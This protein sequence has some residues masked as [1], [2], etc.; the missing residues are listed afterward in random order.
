MNWLRFFKSL[1]ALAALAQVLYAQPAVRTFDDPRLQRWSKQLLDGQR[2]ATLKAVED[3]LVSGNPHPY[4]AEAWVKI[5]MS[6]DRLEPA[7]QSASPA[8]RAA[9]GSRPEIA[10]L[11]KKGHAKELLAK[12]PPSAAS[13]ITDVYS[14]EDLGWSAVNLRRY[15]DAAAYGLR[16]ME[17][18][19]SGFA[20]VWLLSTVVTWDLSLRAQLAEKF[21]PGTA[22]GDTPK[23]RFLSYEF[24]L[25]SL[26]ALDHL[27]EAKKLDSILPFDSE[28]RW[29]EANQL[30]TLER[31]DEAAQAYES[32]TQLFAFESLLPREARCLAALGRWADARKVAA[33]AAALGYPAANAAR[34]TEYTLA[35]AALDAGEKGEARRLLEAAA[36][37]WPDAPNIQ[38]KLARLEI[39]SKRGAQSLPHAR[40]AAA[41]SPDNLERQ[42]LLIEALREAKRVPESWAQFEKTDAAFTEKSDEMF[43]QGGETLHT[44]ERQED[45][46]ALYRRAVQEFPTSTY[47]MNELADALAMAGHKK[48]ALDELRISLSHGPSTWELGKLRT[49]LKEANP[50]S[51]PAQADTEIK[52][53]LD[54]RPWSNTLWEDLADHIEGAD[55]AARKLALFRDAAAKNPGRNWPWNQAMWVLLNDERWADAETLANQALDAT[56]TG[57]AADRASAVWDWSRMVVAHLEKER[58][59][60]AVLEKALANLDAY[61]AM[62]SYVGGY[63]PNRAKLLKALGRK[64]EAA[65]ASEKAMLYRP[66]DEDGAWQLA[67]EY[68]TELGTGKAMRDFE[69]YVD[70]DPYNSTRVKQLVQLN[71]MWTSNPARTL[72]LLADAKD[73]VPEAYDAGYE[74][75][76]RSNLGDYG[77]RYRVDYEHSTSISPSD[78]YVQWYQNTRLHAQEEKL[79]VRFDPNDALIY[80]V[81]HADGRVVRRKK[82][83]L[84]GKLML[85]QVDASKLEVEHDENGDDMKKI[86]D[87]AGNWIRLEYD[88]SHSIS[89]MTGNDGTELTFEYNRMKKPIRIAYKGLGEITVTY[90][91]AG[92]I[93]QVDSTAGRDIALKV[94]GAFQK[95]LDMIRPFESE[96]SREIPELPFK[97]ARADALRA[98]VEVATTPAATRRADLALARYLLDHIADRRAYGDEIQRTLASLIVAGREPGATAAVKVDA[99]AAADLW[100]QTARVLTPHGLPADEWTNW[101]QVRT[102]LE[103][104]PA[105]APSVANAAHTLLAKLEKAP[106]TLLPSAK[107]LP[108]SYIDSPGFWRRYPWSELLPQAVRTAL[109]QCLLVRANHDVVVGTDHGLAILSRGFWKWYGFDDVRAKFSPNV[110]PVGVGPTSNIL[111][112]AEAE[113]KLYVGSAKGL[114]RIAGAY[115]STVTRW[116]G[117]EDGLPSA[118]I[119]ALQTD[120]DRVF[121]GT[122]KG[123]RVLSKDNIAKDNTGSAGALDNE[124]IVLLRRLVN[125]PDDPAQ[126]VVATAS[127]VQALSGKSATTLLSKPVIDLAWADESSRLLALADL[128][129]GLHVYALP[130]A[131]DKDAK[132]EL[133][134]GQQDI[135]KVREMFALAQIPVDNGGQVV[136][137][138]TDRGL[139]IFHDEHFE[140]KDL[141]LSD[142]GVAVYRSASLD[143]RTWFLTSEGVYALERGQTLGDEKGRVYDLLTDA[144]QGLTFVAR[145]DALQVVRHK[146]LEEGAVPFDG[147][148]ATHLARDPQGRL[149]AND[150]DRIVRYAPGSTDAEA[151]FEMHPTSTE[152]FPRGE[153][154]SLLCASDGTI[155][156]TNGADVFRWREGDKDPEDFSIFK[157]PARFPARSEMISRVIETHDHRIWVVASDESHLFYDGQKLEGGFLEWTGSAFRRTDMKDQPGWFMTSYTKLDDTRAIVGTVSGFALHSGDNYAVLR[158]SKNAS[159]KELQD[160]HPMLWL[161][162]RGAKL[163]K[164]TWLFGAA[165]GVI[166]WN[167]TDNR[168]FYPDAIN[169]KLPDDPRF[170]GEY[171]VRTVHAVETDPAGNI[172]AATD[173]GLLI[174]DSGGGDTNSFLISNYFEKDFAFRLAEQRKLEQEAG[175]LLGALPKDSDLAKKVQ[176]FRQA[177]K[178]IAQLREKLWPGV[179][180]VP[181][182][183]MKQGP[184]DPG[185]QP[186]GSD[187]IAALAVAEQVQLNEPINVREKALRDLLIAI[188]KDNPG[189]AQLLELKPLDLLAL[190][191]QFTDGQAALQFLPTSK[192]LYIQIVTKRGTEIREV[193]VPAAELQRRAVQLST[194]LATQGGRGTV[195][196]PGREPAKLDIQAELA[197][198]Y[199]QLLRPVENDLAGV[200]QIFVVP[201]G[202]LSYVPFSALIRTTEPKAEY[203]VERFQFG[204]LP[205]LYLFD[206]VMRAKAG[207]PSRSSLVVGDPDGTLPGARAEANDVHKILGG[208]VLIGEQATLDAI[209]KDVPKARVLHLA[210]HGKLVKPTPEDSWL[211]LANGQHLSVIDTM[212][213]PLQ[214]TDMVVMSAC[215]SALSADGMEYA[216]LARALAQAGTPSILATLWQVPDAPSKEL[217]EH[218]YDYART[219]DRFTA[220]AKAQRDM[221]KSGD[222]DLAKP[223]AWAGYIPFGRP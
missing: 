129:E 182:S 75:M 103:A 192:S 33:R 67:T 91:D 158:D 147:I 156:V 82:H 191:N 187:F 171:G 27:T 215:E 96:N 183:Q 141:G 117:G 89:K 104:Q 51:G 194:A 170:R 146:N 154:T 122:A 203:A 175:L 28:L 169:W 11:R 19:A 86:S 40:A 177:E 114:F 214:D 4:S 190:R 26:D 167:E 88:G 137:V 39:D 54:I 181:A 43:H 193:A 116:E 174:Y 210:T 180:L 93:D 17:L 81:V 95:L 12:Y 73:R 101:T 165:G 150:G 102:W 21:K 79:D 55:A 131:D 15:D 46:V 83:P 42:V 199:D 111:S 157:D 87:S 3:D 172:Y 9:L 133:V 163:D 128:G 212:M 124:P 189:L 6:L 66:D 52:A 64:Q 179:K 186:K 178:E 119:T 34:D 97:D 65:E 195:L 132:P 152:D 138:L 61:L 45:A 2:D 24:S 92:E 72:Q 69:H 10:L 62:G 149:V 30:L 60:P 68:R 47:M 220:L 151:L 58:L 123:L 8:L 70:R 160:K 14:L 135:V 63:Y 185:A 112:L 100:Y 134:K 53:M 20:P 188:Q 84:S 161:G 32:A 78:R 99:I 118:G 41:A 217:I 7:M 113:G 38:E 71:V 105:A 77:G 56:R 159:Y 108:Y 173:R 201:A 209:R 143:G 218:F 196:P 162:T 208:T 50:Q 200:K 207:D 211:M 22:L 145:G 5:Q 80:E 221:L 16:E 142:K 35:V 13:G 168:W 202:A 18:P 25:R 148:A 176:Q 140:A 222:P 106:L 197:W 49:W 94:T 136:A 144:K 120:G 216:T 198:F 1:L 29:Y 110:S 36:A 153:V 109:P 223:G 23:G 130:S 139:S 164:E 31:F 57:P 126:I 98:A 213:L 115:D 107:W 44:L 74:A 90:T 127:G 125:A 205:S 37:K 155:W 121:V 59:S 76:A 48:E 219:D 184:G 204:Y 85:L 206:L 166:A